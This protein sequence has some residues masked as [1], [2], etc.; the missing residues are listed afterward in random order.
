[1]VWTFSDE[2]KQ[3]RIAVNYAYFVQFVLFLV[4]KCDEFALRLG[5]SGN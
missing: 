4:E 5:T 2:A 3:S 1:M